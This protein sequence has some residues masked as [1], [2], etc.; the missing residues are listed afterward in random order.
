MS[1]TNLQHASEIVFHPYLAWLLVKNAVLIAFGISC[2]ILAYQ[3]HSILWLAGIALTA[4]GAA[5]LV[6]HYHA[7]VVII[8]G[9]MF[10][11]RQGVLS[12][13]EHSI[14]LWRLNLEVRRSILGNIL[15]YG[16]VR[17]Y[18]D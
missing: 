9:F 4:C 8:R 12:T 13:R 11:A 16:T 5:L 18:L 15:G 7:N 1:Y 17:L 2:A 14:L 3:T 10:F 6:A